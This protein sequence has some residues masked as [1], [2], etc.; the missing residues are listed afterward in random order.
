MNTY[1]KTEK[2]IS[3][4]TEETD[5]KYEL[6]TNS[7]EWIQDTV[8]AAIPGTAKYL[9]ICLASRGRYSMYPRPVKNL[10]LCEER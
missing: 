10:G 1:L 5:L 4:Q 9:K 8:R 7:N 6:H 3:S 2:Q